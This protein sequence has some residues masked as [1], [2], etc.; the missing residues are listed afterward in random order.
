MWDFVHHVGMHAIDEEYVLA[1]AKLGQTRVI[2]PACAPTR[3]TKNEATLSIKQDEAGTVWHCWHCDI[4]GSVGRAKVSVVPLKPIQTDEL[5]DLGIE[6]L[7]ER[8]IS[9]DTARAFGVVSGVKFFKK[10]ALELPAIG[11]TYFHNDRLSAVKWRSVAG[12]EFTQDGS[13]QT[14]F[15]AERIEPGRDLV[16]TEGELDALSFWE[17]GIPAVS[18]PSGALNEGAGDDTA[19]L[20]WLTYHDELIR[21]A[22]NIYLAV[23]MDGPGNTTANELAR[24]VGKLKCWRVSFPGGCKDANETLVRLGRE[25]LIKAHARAERW[26]VEGLSSP[27]DFM[28]KVQ[29]LYRN[30]LPRGTSSGWASVDEIFTLNPG[31]LVI[32]TGTPGSGKSQVIDNMLVH[33]M[34]DSN[35]RVA[36]SSFEN[37]P[38]LHLA[39]LISLQTGKPFG[40]GPTPRI[41]EDE[42]GEA[43][44]WIN[45]RVTFLTN[46]GVMPTVESLVERFEAAVRRSGVKACV[47]DPFNFI[48][49]SA[50][51]DG[52]IDTESINE[53]LAQFKTFAVRA[54][55]TFF[56]IAHPAKPMNPG[57]DWVPTGYSISG[58]A[59]FYNRADFGVTIQRK[60]DESIF[61]VWKCRFPW[62]G[63]LGAASLT[64]EKT[65]GAFKEKGFV[66]PGEPEDEVLIRGYNEAAPF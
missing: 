29:A 32:V 2:C 6:Y 52:G 43:M 7:A 10:S 33:A 16:I 56:L 15:L 35:W 44:G 20:R 5:D 48:K 25:A 34:R 24:R 30:G 51:K 47:V 62:Q 65:T 42:M 18:I 19:R 55:V 12:K 58:S 3:K 61:H 41:T 59:H 53:M 27:S 66:M 50:K 54:E 13:A 39:K 45:D 8:G 26:P 28:D 21:E 46:E 14:L 49:L 60:M 31:S 57:P 37:P 40:E 9:A 63:Q 36:Y 38:E 1:K 17:I 64:Y 11:F 4:K 22:Q 23:D